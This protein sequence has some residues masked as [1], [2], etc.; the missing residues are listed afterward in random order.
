[1]ECSR[2]LKLVHNAGSRFHASPSVTSGFHLTTVSFQA[3]G[4]QLDFSSAA[5]NF[6]LMLTA[7]VLCS[8]RTM[9]YQIM[10]N[11]AAHEKTAQRHR[12]TFLSR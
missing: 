9:V 8:A 6:P 1:M 7:V 3:Q 5:P 11:E 4:L 10:A 2:L 12:T